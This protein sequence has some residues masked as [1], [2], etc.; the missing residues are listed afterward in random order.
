[1]SREKDILEGVYEEKKKKYKGS[2]CESWRGYDENE[3]I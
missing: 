1:M 2:Y 3:F